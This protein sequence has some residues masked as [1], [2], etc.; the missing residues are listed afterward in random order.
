MNG[1]FSIHKN[2]GPLQGKSR[3]TVVGTA[4]SLGNSHDS[5]SKLPD[6]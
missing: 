1:F 4:H 5:L 2:T 3:E 6:V